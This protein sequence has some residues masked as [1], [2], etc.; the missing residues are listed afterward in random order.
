MS[1]NEE[2]A[3]KI[4]EYL[5]E[6]D[7]DDYSRWLP[8]IEDFNS[9]QIENLLYGKRDYRYPVKNKDFF[10]NLVRKFDNFEA[11]TTKWYQKEENYKYLKQL[12]LQYICIEDIRLMLKENKN[13]EQKLINYLEEKKINYSLWPNEI[14]E[15]FKKYLK[16]AVG[17]EIFDENF[18]KKCNEEHSLFKQAFESI[19]ALKNNIKNL[20]DDVSEKSKILFEKNSNS[21]VTSV[22]TSVFTSMVLPKLYS[23]AIGSIDYKCFEHFL[24]RQMQ[25]YS[26]N[27][28]DAKKIA[29]DIIKS[30]ICPT[31]GILNWKATS[32]NG[33]S[34]LD[35]FDDTWDNCTSKGN[36]DFSEKIMKLNL[37]GKE[38]ERITLFKG[39]KTILKNN[40]VCG[41]ISLISFGN[42]CF[43]VYLFHQISK[44][45]EEV[46]AKKYKTQLEN[47]KK[48]FQDHLNKLNLTGNAEECYKNINYVKENIE[49][50]LK[51]LK[52]LVIEIDADIMSYKK[53]KKCSIGSLAVS[54]LC[55]GCAAIGSA[56]ATNG[57][58]FGFYIGSCVFNAISGVG[59]A[60]DI[61]KC[62]INIEKLEEIKKDAEKVRA[63]IE[64]QIEEL[65]LMLHKKDF[66]FPSYYQKCNDIF[67][68]QNTEAQNYNLIKNEF[69]NR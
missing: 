3:R 63:D 61:K 40:I 39:I 15:E 58:S 66:S 64:K 2:S 25:E 55:G 51:N 57:I 65:N 37:E 33:I 11:L 19:K 60:M 8:F 27:K 4:I 6:D 41:L 69:L 62:N 7:I 29:A 59:N 23:A 49:A 53:L 47:I 36:F 12:W 30:N 26:I 42:L 46:E 17:T 14:K 45:T 10:Y 20:F 22:V 5:L 44:H 24:V 1:F 28:C 56:V 43:S 32:S 31:D 16:R 35:L 52:D 54:I 48:N 68:K 50:D 21:L 18:K 9:E 34:L 38:D 13:D 67:Q